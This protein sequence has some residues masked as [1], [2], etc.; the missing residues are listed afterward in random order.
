MPGKPLTPDQNDR[1]RQALR[2]LLKRHDDSQTVVAKKLG[3]SQPTL[4]A[5]LSGRQGTSYTIVV[6][7]A[8]FLGIDASDILGTT[9]AQTLPTSAEASRQLAAELA[10]QDGVQLAA[11]LSVLSEPI[12][13][14]QGDVSVLWWIDRMRWREREMFKRMAQGSPKESGVTTVDQE[15]LAAG[16]RA[17][18]RKPDA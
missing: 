11:V 10:K 7:L 9:S 15:R 17:R 3:V 6:R 14:D 16:P 18:A 8:L 5:F 1:A 4:S 2:T 12:E 13:A